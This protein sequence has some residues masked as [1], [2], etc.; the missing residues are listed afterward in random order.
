MSTTEYPFSLAA[1]S[2]KLEYNEKAFRLVNH[3]ENLIRVPL[4]NV[5]WARLDDDKKVTV[6]ILAPAGEKL[7]L[8]NLEGEISSEAEAV[9]SAKEWITGLMNHAYTG[10]KSARKLKVLLNPVGG[11]GK[12]RQ[13][14][15][16]E[17][18]PIFEAAHCDVDL[19]V[20]ERHGHM[21]EITEKMS[22]DYDA[23]V[24][25]SGDG[26]VHEV[27][28]GLA[29]NSQPQKALR[30]PIAQMPTGSA[31]AVCVNTFGVKDA[32]NVSKAS[33][34][35][36]KGKPMHHPLYSIIQG[37]KTYLSF[38]TQ[39]IG[40]MADL[41]LGTEHL[42]WMSD[43]RFVVGYLRGVVTKK[44]SPIEIEYILVEDDKNKMLETGK[45]Q[46][47][48]THFVGEESTLDLEAPLPWQQDDRHPQASQE[49]EW[50]RLD[51]QILYVYAGGFPFVSRDLMQFPL[52]T[53]QDDHI[54]M[55]VQT[56]ATRGTM[57]KAIVG[58]EKG[59]QFWIPSQL[60]LKVRKFRVTPKGK[61]YLSVDG[62]GYP[63]ESFE[64]QVH[65]GIIRFLSMDGRYHTESFYTSH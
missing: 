15:E 2:G 39:A 13:I 64:V 57:L 35:V 33:L 48:G 63:F 25:L 32:F 55:V 27:I 26:G 36:I 47:R 10:I 65:P 45:S 62:E 38:L 4:L 16:R 18:L 7:V 49:G 58:A 60:Y 1:T 23:I 14:Y 44:V 5:L 34:N 17:V 52:A 46:G 51:K 21:I 11:K 28:N 24:I 53:P 3:G 22:V 59:Q 43:A 19:T 9:K 40:L 12:A 41:D 31:N 54:D 56:M 42:R 37:D 20:S 50:K 6:T 29:K 61:G 30:I 8:K